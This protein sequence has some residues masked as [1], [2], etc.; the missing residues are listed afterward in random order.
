MSGCPPSDLLS[1]ASDNI[2][3]SCP[4]AADARIQQLCTSDLCRP[5]QTSQFSCE[6]LK[7]CLTPLPRR[8]L[9]RI[10]DQHI[11]LDAGGILES[12]CVD[13][14]LTSCIQLCPP[15]ASTPIRIVLR[16]DDPQACGLANRVSIVVGG[17][18]IPPLPKQPLAIWLFR[19]HRE[20]LVPWALWYQKKMPVA[21][22]STRRRTIRMG[23]QLEMRLRCQL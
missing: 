4:A 12:F 6:W 1:G 15:L 11:D 5:F 16:R 23:P 3:L 2:I 9:A 18:G 7:C 14:T 13:S 20:Y 8:R 17:S 22:S 21:V 19:Q 10:F